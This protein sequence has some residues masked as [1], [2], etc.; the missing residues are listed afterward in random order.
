MSR[1]V[2]C[3]RPLQMFDPQQTLS[4]GLKRGFQLSCHT[5]VRSIQCKWVVVAVPLATEPLLIFLMFSESPQS[6]SCSIIFEIFLNEFDMNLHL[7]TAYFAKHSTN[8]WI[9]K[10]R[11]YEVPGQDPL[12]L[13]L[14]AWAFLWLAWTLFCSMIRIKER[15]QYTVKRYYFCAAV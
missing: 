2:T 4:A 1:H 11:H 7:S 12:S 15:G 13:N 5:K 9:R 3:V 10:S 8:N 6:C 14:H